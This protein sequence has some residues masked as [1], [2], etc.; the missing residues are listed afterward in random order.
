MFY[1]LCYE[2]IKSIVLIIVL[3][4][5]FLY[6]KNL[7]IE[8]Y[9]FNPPEIALAEYIKPVAIDKDDN[10]TSS[11]KKGANET[12]IIDNKVN[13]STY[14]STRDTDIKD[15]LLNFINNEFGDELG[16]EFDNETSIV[17]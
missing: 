17:E 16:D 5:L 4:Y 13:N 12:A 11:N 9:E 2:L 14:N 10:V 7:F 3:H 15:E 1:E 6:L 8:V